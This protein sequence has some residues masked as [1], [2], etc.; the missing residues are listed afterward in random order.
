MQKIITEAWPCFKWI[1]HLSQATKI[2]FWVTISILILVL[3]M[4]LIIVLIKK[5]KKKEHLISM[6]IENADLENEESV[7]VI[8]KEE[9]IHKTPSHTHDQ[10]EL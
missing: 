10:K 4:I 6:D 9:I 1:F 7:R 3:I 2:L 5:N 8:T